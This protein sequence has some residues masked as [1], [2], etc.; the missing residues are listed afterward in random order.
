ME[1]GLDVEK[2]KIE[3]FRFFSCHVDRI[4]K[5]RGLTQEPIPQYRHGTVGIGD[6]FR[7]KGMIQR[8]SGMDQGGTKRRKME[9]FRQNE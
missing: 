9:A 4:V 7:S 5:W 6:Q 8:G 2:G 1:D 3:A